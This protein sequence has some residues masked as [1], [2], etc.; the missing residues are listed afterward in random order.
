MC[1]F[2]DFKIYSGLWPLLVSPRCQWV[3]TM[4]GQTPA[5][6]QKNDMLR[7]NT[8]FNEHPVLKSTSSEDVG[9]CCK[10]GGTGGRTD[11]GCEWLSERAV[12][13]GSPVSKSLTLYILIKEKTRLSNKKKSKKQ[14][15][16]QEKSKLKDI[17]F[18]VIN[19]RLSCSTN[20]IMCQK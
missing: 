2:E 7:K 18:Y 19:I 13:R 1:F 16:D 9:P 10:C 6:K 11:L 12:N 3:Y 5:L 8:I 14:D 15:F 20:F 4:A 17:T